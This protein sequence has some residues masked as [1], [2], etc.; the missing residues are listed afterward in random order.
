MK[1]NAPY[2]YYNNC[3]TIQN[4]RIMKK[5]LLFSL[6]LV[7]LSVQAEK[8]PVKKINVYVCTP[9]M[10]NKEGVVSDTVTFKNMRRTIEQKVNS[11]DRTCAS[12]EL[13]QCEYIIQTFISGFEK[14]YLSPYELYG[15]EGVSHGLDKGDYKVNFFITHYLFYFPL[16][17]DRSKGVCLD[18]AH[19]VGKTVLEP[20]SNASITSYEDA[21]EGFCLRHPGTDLIH[22]LLDGALVVRGTI[23][24]VG[25]NADGKDVAYIDKGYDDGIADDQWF[26]ICKKN[27][28]GSAGDVIGTMKAES[29]EANRSVCELKK[30]SGKVLSAI[31]SG[32]PLVV[33][34]RVS[35]NIFKKTR[36]AWRDFKLNGRK[37]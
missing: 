12:R 1:K 14:K 2:Q 11:F 19:T 8:D 34:T 7:C 10:I 22:N 36:A 13:N 25:K 32:V 20:K 33:V 23:T 30:N 37:E 16:S 28:D 31:R 26:N 21:I 29:R 35:S 5:L 3:Q 18:E 15:A 27:A 24:G 4:I 6:C 17:E 9:Q